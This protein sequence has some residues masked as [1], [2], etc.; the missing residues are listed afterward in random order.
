[1]KGLKITYRLLG[2]L[3]GLLLQQCVAAQALNYSQYF[4]SPLLVNPANTGFNPDYD[5]RAGLNYRNSFTAVGGGYKTMGVW[6][7]AKLFANRF[8]NGWMGIGGSIIKDVAGTGQLTATGASLSLAWHQMLGYKSLLS[9]GFSAG[10][11]TKRV[12]I[13]KLNFDNQ[14][15]GQFFD[16]SIPSNE[17]FAFSQVGYLDLNMG[18]NYAYFASE[19]FY[20]NAGVSMMH[21]NRPR[22]SFFAANIS[23]AR[24]PTRFNFFANASI[25]LE[26]MW[27]LNPNIYF[28]TIGNK[29]ELVMGMNANRN[30]GGNGAQQMIVGLYYRN[31]DAII[32]MIGYSVN[33]LQITVNYDA[34]ISSLGRLNA[35]R[36]AYELS[37]IKHGIFSSSGGRSVKCP[38]VRF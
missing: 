24:V 6:A 4:N 12:D 33:D 37:I 30:L 28:S 23:D 18:L 31:R 15:N 16:V 11:T 26:D 13:A 5:Y 25:K 38:T 29:N 2:V 20:F 22:E 8:E 27:I 3:L 14:W 32:P 17:P 19:N 10:V 21:I 9:A 34:T 1:M 7:D 35:T 36:G